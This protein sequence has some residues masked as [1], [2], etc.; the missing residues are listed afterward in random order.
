MLFQFWAQG[1]YFFIINIPHWTHQLGYISFT[2]STIGFNEN[3]EKNRLNQ[4]NGQHGKDNQMKTAAIKTHKNIIAMD[5][6]HTRNT[7][8]NHGNNNK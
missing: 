1:S 2:L 8:K 7:I 6:K 3:G 4:M 5:S